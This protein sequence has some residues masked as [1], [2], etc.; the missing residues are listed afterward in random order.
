MN[1]GRRFFLGDFY[2]TAKIVIFIM[3]G[4]IFASMAHAGVAPVYTASNSNQAVGGYDVVSYFTAQKAQKGNIDFQTNWKGATWLF[5]SAQHKEAFVKNPEKYAPQYGGYCS[6]AVSQGYT[7]KGDPN[8][9]TIVKDK[10]YL[11]YSKSVRKMWL[12]NIQANIVA[13]NGHW[14]K[15]LGE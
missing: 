10:L 14:P 8:A 7:A 13:G 12:K 11:N 3:V 4:A 9:W 2:V 5:A 6:F 15:I 1:I